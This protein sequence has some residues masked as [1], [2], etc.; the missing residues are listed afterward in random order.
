MLIPGS[1]E[2]SRIWE[3]VITPG[4]L[5]WGGHSGSFG[6]T[7]SHHEGP[8]EGQGVQSETGVRGQTLSQGMKICASGFKDRVEPQAGS[9]GRLQRPGREGRGGRQPCQRPDFSPVKPTADF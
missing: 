2:C 8:D 1:R 9:T 4:F 7:K 6:W 5:R 3:K